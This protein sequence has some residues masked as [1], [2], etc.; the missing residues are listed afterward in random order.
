MPLTFRIALMTL[1]RWARLS[2]STTIVLKTVPS[3]VRELGRLHVGPGLADRL[4]DIGVEPATILAAHGQ[5][6]GEG[7]TLR[8]PASRFRPGALHP[9][10]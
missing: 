7:L 9:T 3:F 8:L 10:G 1:A 5:P 2:T 4:H 6:D